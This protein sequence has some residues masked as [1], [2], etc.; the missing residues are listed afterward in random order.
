MV[1]MQ[2]FVIFIHTMSDDIYKDTAEDVAI[3]LDTSTYELEGPLSKGKKKKVIG[4]MKDEW[5]DKIVG[6][7]AGWRAK[8]YS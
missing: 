6:E 1:K 8:I 7:F 5:G 2:N 4:T 3:R